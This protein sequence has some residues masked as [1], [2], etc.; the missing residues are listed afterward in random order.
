MSLV[1]KDTIDMRENGYE[2]KDGVLNINHV[3]GNKIL[4]KDEKTDAESLF[5]RSC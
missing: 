1:F 4:T 3:F 2:E 5:T